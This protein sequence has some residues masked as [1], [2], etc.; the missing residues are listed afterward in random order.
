MK[1]PNNRYISRKAFIAIGI[2][3]LAIT[4]TSI[5]FLSSSINNSN[6]QTYKYITQKNFNQKL[7]ALQLEFQNLD[8]HLLS[9]GV[10]TQESSLETLKTQFEVLSKVYNNGRIIRLNWFLVVDE[11][12]NVVDYYLGENR[13]FNTDHTFVKSILSN[14]ISSGVNNFVVKD[15]H[16]YWLMYN[17]HNLKNGNKLIYGMTLDM[18]NFHKYLTTIDVTTPNYAYIFTIDGLCI[19]HPEIS[20]IGKNVFELSSLQPQDTIT[21][22]KT[23]E[24]PVVLSEYLNLEVFRFISHFDSENFKGYITV[25]FPKFN[26]DDNVKPTQR[27]TIL[28]FITTVSLIVLLFYFFSQANKRAHNEKKQLEVENEKVNKEKALMQLQQLKNQINPHFLFN[29]LNSLYMLIDIDPETAQKFTLNL[30]KTYRYLITPP[31]DNIVDLNDEITFIRKYITLQ[32]IR[33]TKELHFE[34]ID[35]KEDKHDC[36]IPYLA[37]QITVEN[38]LKHNIA[39]VETPLL[40][41]IIIE[42]DCVI[43]TNNYNPKKS[44]QQGE[45]FGL[46][47]LESI[48]KYYNKN[49]FK[50][51]QEG[52]T[53]V[54]V[55]PLFND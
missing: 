7:G 9:L 33:F 26:V 55:L 29:S 19:Y 21:S 44:Q 52:D 48:Y 40:I 14:P 12:N 32:Q 50:A 27:N 43:V 13:K 22:I 30:S 3:I 1:A 8:E 46:R 41:Q 47:Y 39:T 42:N 53:F 4:M 37:L 18:E 20:L 49:D 25:N 54:C 31:E 24:P 28:I 45:L 6:Q 51:T 17:S 15:N 5:Y 38:A 36:K 23:T 10:I 35:K 34:L 16:Y 2:A 11:H